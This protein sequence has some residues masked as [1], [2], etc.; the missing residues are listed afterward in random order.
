MIYDIRNPNRERL[1]ATARRLQTLLPDVVFVGGQLTELLV[2]DPASPHVRPTD[3]VDVIVR[4]TTRT[5]YH[6]L[7]E[8]LAALGFQP[9]TTPDS[10]ICRFRT[11]D[12][13]VLDVMPLDPAILGF[14]NRWY[15]YAIET[16]TSISLEPDLE[17]RAATAPAFLATKWEAFR[18]RGD[19]NM[20]MS[21][22]VED[23]ITLV[24]GRPSIVNEVRGAHPEVR[25][26]IVSQIRE[27]LRDDNAD[28]IV[29]DALPDA[30]RV[31]GLVSAV[32]E[33]LEALV[34]Q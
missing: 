25:H 11:E 27:L 10:P 17:I 28:E 9:D 7:Q 2:T 26:F 33:R 5:A 16:A 29:E 31:R 13:L 14:T 12:G 3:D 19:N 24:A 23:I 22:D 34:A 4:V 1:V 21:H 15:S 30:R 18:S 8:R 32:M 6:E 20:L